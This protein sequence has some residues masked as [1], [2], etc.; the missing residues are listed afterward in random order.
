MPYHDHREQRLRAFEHMYIDKLHIYIYVYTYCTHFSSLF[1]P[2]YTYIIL[3]AI[4]Y[5]YRVYRYKRYMGGVQNS[6]SKGLYLAGTISNLCYEAG[7]ILN[8]AIHNL[9]ASIARVWR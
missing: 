2:T 4:M 8:D 3:H 7:P 9:S 6:W 1:I 5:M